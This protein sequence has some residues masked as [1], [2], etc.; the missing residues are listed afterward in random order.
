[1]PPRHSV[2]LA[3]APVPVDERGNFVAE[4]VLPKG[5]HTVEVA[6]LDEAG[7][8]ELFLRDLEMK[9]DD[10][11]YVG[12]ADLTLSADLAGEPESALHGENGPFDPDSHADGRIAFFTTGKFWDDWKL[13]AS[14]DTREEPVGELFKDFVKKTPESLFR[15]I[16]PDYYYPTFGDDGTVDEAAPTSGKFYVK[17]D[18]RENH[19][20]WG[21]F[22]VGY[23]DNELVQVDR[24]LYGGN[25]HYQTLATTR[26]GEQRLAVDGFA[27]EPGTVPSREE[28]RGTEGSLYFLRRQDLLVGSE[29]LRVEV[30]DKDSGLVTGVVHLRPTID[31]DID[32]L[33]GRILLTEPLSSTVAD[34]L[35]VHS[36]G[37]SGDEAWLVVRYEFTPGFE[38]LDALSTGGTGHLWATDWLKFGVTGNRNEDDGADSTLYGGDVTARLSTES[39]AKVQAGKSEGLVTSTFRSDD[40]GFLFAGIG[41]A[42]ALTEADA[43]AYRADVSLG[44]AD[45]IDGARG[46]IALYGQTLGEGYSGP[47]MTALTDTEQFGGVLGVPI[48]KRLSFTAKG[49]QRTQDDGLA[50]R[51]AEVDLG[52]RLTD[53]WSLGA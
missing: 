21:N 51:A 44:I 9:R 23:L 13:T 22:K 45:F 34:N 48:T 1:M 14:A 29:R 40:G 38:E 28:F 47:G 30:R 27:A 35:L 15:R 24:G 2:F 46:R 7:N 39:W 53:H 49:D 10:W 19:A 4:V 5:A 12:I 36:D 18:Q 50:T 42:A 43:E 52:Y 32:Y 33:Q 20:M 31:Y 37:F 11:F 41:S 25:V 3:G 6:V 17:V 26:Y 16:D 8:G